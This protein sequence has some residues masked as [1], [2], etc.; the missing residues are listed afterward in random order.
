MKPA[1]FEYYDPAT[2]DE[3]LALLAEFGDEAKPL[4]GG[5]SLVPLMNF[6]LARPARLVDLNLLA[7]LSYVRDED[8]W[9]RI[10]A[11]T[12]QRQLERSP[13]AAAGWPLLV[14]A[15]AYVG[16]PPIRH[17]GTVGGSV[18][19]AD[20]AAELPVVMAALD[21]ELV[22]R[23][24]AGERTERAGGFFLSYLTTTL[25]PTELLVEL[26]V[27]PLPPRSGGAF[28]EVSRRHGDFALVGAAALVTLD[29]AGAIAGARLAIAGA[30]PT[31]LRAARAE[32]RL[33]GERPAEALFREAGRLVSE[34]VDSDADVHASADYRREVSGVL[35][36]RALLQAA[37]RAREQ[38][39]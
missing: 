9:L 22:I 23:A 39:S 7:E 11:M 35:A 19:H 8:G 12:R 4:A 30:G 37:A 2:L 17:R 5:Q 13:L 28:L 18:A 6:R 21:A 36:R 20:P 29:A 15:T 26:R 34:A 31:P 33:L 1:P 32:A 27:P 3:A 38:P 14:E 25:A 10:G 24:Q 16:H